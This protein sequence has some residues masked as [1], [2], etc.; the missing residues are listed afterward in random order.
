MRYE[1]QCL[2]QLPGYETRSEEKRIR[3]KILPWLPMTACRF[4][5]NAQLP[6]QDQAASFLAP[7]V[8]IAD[9][10]KRRH[11][12]QAYR[13]VKTQEQEKRETMILSLEQPHLSS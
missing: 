3:E 9:A 13:K 11:C 12:G 8:G 7:G 5:L 6:S 4:R 10:E 2:H 1:L